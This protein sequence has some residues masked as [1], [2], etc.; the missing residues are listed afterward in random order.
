ML[1]VDFLC[2]FVYHRTMQPPITKR[3]KEM[4][5]FIRSYIVDHRNSPTIEQIQNQMSMKWPNSVFVMLR[6]LEE[7]GYILRRKHAKRNIELRNADSDGL[8]SLS[9]LSIPIVA[10]VG[11]DDLRTYA[12]EQ[13]DEFLEVDK[14]LI[15]NPRDTVAVRAVGNSMNDAAGINNGDYI[16]VELTE[17]AHNG[18]RVVAVIGD[19]ITVK[20][21]ERRP[22]L[23]ILRPESKDPIY[24]PIVKREDFKIAGKV[25]S[26]IPNPSSILT[27]VIPIIESI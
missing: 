16:L 24:K 6:A 9:I 23:T 4:L 3:Q 17:D 18:E 5:E 1:L 19:M 21:L 15:N 25:I 7:K 8:P 22:G 26:V 27:E 13:H 2:H 10:S 14:V 12:N 11:C 20:K